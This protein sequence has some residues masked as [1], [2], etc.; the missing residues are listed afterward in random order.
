MADI[1]LTALGM[2]GSGK[3]CFLVA[4]YYAMSAGVNG[5]TMSMADAED[6]YDL[7]TKWKN[8]SELTGEMRFPQGT[9]KNGDY[10]F[11]LEYAYQT[12]K[13][14]HWMDYRG[15]CI[16]NH[17][18]DDPS[19]YE[20][21]IQR[22]NDSTCLFIFVDGEKMV[23]DDKDKVIVNVRDNC[24]SNINNLISVYRKTNK[25][26]PQIAI[27]IT[28]YDKCRN[29]GKDD[30]WDIVTKAFSPLFTADESKNQVTIIPVSIGENIDDKEY[31]GA[32]KPINIEKPLFYAIFNVLKKDL[33]RV[34]KEQEEL[35]RLKTLAEKKLEDKEEQLKEQN[36]KIRIAQNLI[37]PKKRAALVAEIENTKKE[38]ADL[39]TKLENIN[40]DV[41]KHKRYVRKIRSELLDLPVYIHGQKYEI[42]EGEELDE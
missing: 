10:L 31:S 5:Y 42:V 38:F 4:M 13:S 40:E 28:K 7:R 24:S 18:I 23:G 29:W 36:K 21:L 32:L 14:F 35:V 3:T 8:M 25:R 26:L 41:A 9:D 34:K 1:N 37:N 22:I 30:I 15:G 6:D 27:I 20:E 16:E 19:Q 33:R 17:G 39:K 12:I 2:S 11:D